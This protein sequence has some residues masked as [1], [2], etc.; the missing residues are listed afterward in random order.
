VSDH[1][2]A[3]LDR[4]LAQYGPALA[5][6]ARM[7]AP[8]PD[9]ANDLLQE[10]AWALWRALPTFRGASSERTFVFRIA[11]NRGLT[12]RASRR[13]SV[14]LDEDTPDGRALP[15]ES[16]LAADRVVHLRRA[17][18]RLPAEGQQV[19]MLRLEGLTDREI[20][21]VVGVSEGNVAVRLTR[22]RLSIR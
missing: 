17:I 14:P 16:V 18:A 10:I 13:A 7:Y 12:F 8:T 2:D 20:A 22:A 11:H 3:T 6:L 9:D 19:V 5:R 21:E 15:D 1:A 4:V